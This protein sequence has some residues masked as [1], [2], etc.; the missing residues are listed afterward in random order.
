MSANLSLRSIVKRYEPTAADAVSDFSLDVAAGEFVTL[1]GPSG[2]GKTT[3]LKMIAG[4]EHPTAGEI[5]VGGTRITEL[6]PYS[7]G[8][9]MVFQSYALFPHMTVFENVAFPLS[10]RSHGRADVQSK[11]AAALNLVQLGELAERYPTQLSGG[12]QQRV[13]LARAVV[14]NPTLLLMDEPL[15]ALDRNLR[16]SMKYEIKRVQRELDMTVVY[17]THDQDEALAMSDRVCVV[18]HGRLVQIGT[19]REIYDLPRSS[20]VARF[21]GESNLLEGKLVRRSKDSWFELAEGVAVPVANAPF[22]FP[23]A[24]VLM[25]R[26]ERIRLAPADLQHDTT[27]LRAQVAEAVFLGES[28]RYNI[29]CG[30]FVL[31]VKQQNVDGRSFDV[32]A[33]VSVSW[34][35]EAAT[36][37]PE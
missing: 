24:C 14:F 22:D 1:L 23:S 18:H 19:A 6:P 5:F 29:R 25:I 27:W 3:I 33:D 16:E 20:F 17:V 9:G 4:F 13:A 30:S 31:T 34:P 15:G 28:T 37:L 26:P 12:Q 21:I 7:R 32:G 11:V 10:V 36:L 35:R 2:S 8:V